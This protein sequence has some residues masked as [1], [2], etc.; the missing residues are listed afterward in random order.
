MISLG[1]L[2][3]QADNTQIGS[4]NG[5]SS[6]ETVQTQGSTQDKYQYDGTGYSAINEPKPEGGKLKHYL[7][8]IAL[9]VIL[10]FVITLILHNFGIYIP[11]QNIANTTA[12]STISINASRAYL[13]NFSF[14]TKLKNLGTF[15]Y[16]NAYCNYKEYFL[17]Y[18]QDGVPL[19]PGAIN[20]SKL[21]ESEPIF[22]SFGVE[23]I[24]G[25]IGRY[26][27]IVN[28]T[29]GY[30]QEAFREISKNSHYSSS[31]A[32]IDGMNAYV[33]NFS[34]FTNTG[35]NMTQTYY[36]GVRPDLEWQITKVIYKNVALVTSIWWFAGSAN[37]TKLY[38]YSSNFY[39]HFISESAK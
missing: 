34:N 28:S 17:D 5:N 11:L 29:G 19:P 23:N 38:N 36:I 33:M 24:N 26:L 12:P 1:Y 7:A 30:C 35:L 2:N 32:S 15:V 31:K 8:A 39:S 16:S 37:N 20:F 10:F 13:G 4:N 27:S 22:V 9:V 21:N 25:S 14:N 18:A 6:Q 3:Y